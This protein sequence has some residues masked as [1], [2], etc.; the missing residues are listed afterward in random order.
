MKKTI[1]ILLV[2]VI[3][4]S[5][6]ACGSDK[7]A[8]KNALQGSWTAKWTN[9]GTQ[10]SRYYT[11]KGNTYTTGGVAFFGELETETGTFEVM[12]T[13]IR[14]TPDDGSSATELDYTYNEK[15]GIVSLWWND[16]IQFQSGTVSVQY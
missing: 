15:T 14:L 3:C 2:L 4:V 12:D 8:V 16:D 5:L 9:Q 10:I 7:E 13:C 11:F 6:G 1:A